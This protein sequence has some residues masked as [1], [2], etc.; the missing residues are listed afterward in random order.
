LRVLWQ[1]EY[2]ERP[3]ALTLGTGDRRTAILSRNGWGLRFD[4]AGG[5]S[6]AF[7]ARGEQRGCRLAVAVT[8]IDRPDANAEY[9]H[10]GAKE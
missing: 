2:A 7:L 9:R 4:R 8:T 10:G 6:P 1:C 5:C 3:R